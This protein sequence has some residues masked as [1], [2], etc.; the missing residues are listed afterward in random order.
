LLLVNK[1]LNMQNNIVVNNISFEPT[2]DFFVLKNI[3]VSFGEKKIG[4][5]GNNGTGKTVLL[6]LLVGEIEPT[7]GKI[8]RIGKIAYLPQDYQIDLKKT[9]GE[10][11]EIVDKL[12]A[13]EKIKNG[14]KNESLLEIVGDDWDIYN[15]AVEK[16]EY[17]NLHNIDFNRRLETL[18]GGEKVK[19]ILAKLL[20]AKPDFIILDEPTNNLDQVSREIVY[21]LVKNWKQ[22][23]L[24]VSHDR[25]LLNLF[26][27]IYELSEGSL[28]LYGGNYDFYKEQKEIENQS[29]KR[30]LGDA[31][32]HFKKVKKQAEKT[33]EQQQKR[34]E[35]G[36]KRRDKLGMG[37]TELD[38]M[39]DSSET[40]TSR[41]SKSHDKIINEAKEKLE[42]AKDKI[43]PENLIVADLSGTNVPEGKLIIGMKDTSFSYGDKKIFE[44]FN[45]SIY[46]PKRLA[47]EGVNGSGKTTLIKL[48]LQILK[49]D[50]GEVQ[51]GV[52]RFAYLDQ[53]FTILDKEKDILENIKQISKINESLARD[54]LA[55][56]MFK[57]DNIFKKV[58]V[59]SGGERMRA[60]L[61]CILAGEEPPQL[62][63]LDEPTNNL[64]LNSIEQIESV[65]LNFEG[66]LIVVSH[67]KKFLEN[68]GVDENLMLI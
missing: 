61:A 35:S 39:K 59:L 8:Q 66:A 20:I 9:V 30:Q 36:K 56:F 31:K 22:G 34:A 4:L 58:K 24:V 5:V 44:N 42:L 40:T 45:L 10:A 37:K 26:D 23:L 16:L 48:M 18:S 64:D 41:L 2:D 13:L 55:K 49:P 12:K 65:L 46:G 54:W 38:L 43:A 68:I 1:F 19:I 7:V 6:K 17:F 62:L 11:L 14:D 57:S 67:D 53:N 50:S 33:L 51:I 52:K 47:I 32:K 63:I 21:N 28:K 27:Q 25:G 15:R 3:S 29:V 60:A